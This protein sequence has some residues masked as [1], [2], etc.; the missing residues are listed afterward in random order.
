MCVSSGLICVLLP[1]GYYW[2]YD[3]LGL[4]FYGQHQPEDDGD[5]D[6]DIDDDIDVHI[7]EILVV[8]DIKGKQLNWSWSTIRELITAN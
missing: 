1:R 2:V 5:I 6:G 8:F 4:S 3:A 7:T